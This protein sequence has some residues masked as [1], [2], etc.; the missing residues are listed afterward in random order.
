MAFNAYSYNKYLGTV[1]HNVLMRIDSARK[2]ANFDD[3]NY[4]PPTDSYNYMPPISRVSF[5]AQ[6]HRASEHTKS[7]TRIPNHKF[8]DIHTRKGIKLVLKVLNF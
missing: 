3:R 7:L 4:V 5:S 8:L 2:K 1:E 6:T